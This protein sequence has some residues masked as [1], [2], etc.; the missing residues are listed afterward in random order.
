MNEQTTTEGDGAI[1]VLGLQRSGTT[2][3]AN[4]IVGSGVVAAVTAPEH[5]GVHESVFFSHFARAFGEFANPTARA[6]FEEALA[7]SDYFLLT[8][9]PRAFLRDT[10]ATAQD[11]AEVFERLMRRVMVDQGSRRWLEKSPHH[12]L[13]AA[14]LAARYPKAQFICVARRSETLLASRLAAYGRIPSR[15]MKRL[16]DL[17]RGALVNALYTRHLTGF[18]KGN[19]QV[20]MMRYDDFAKDI[21]PGRA[22]LIDFLRLPVAP[23]ALHSAFA[24]NSSHAIDGKTRMLSAVDRLMIRLGDGLGAVLP[25]AL[26]TAIEARRR[27]R[28]GTDWPDWVWQKSGWRP[29]LV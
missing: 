6:D 8:G 1:F 21:E 12:T 11:Y 4:M 10:V 15:G 25:L 23:T 27:K 29:P 20:L 7:Q 28:R 18:A 5:Q 26:L 3:L 14:E 13:L 19:P 2:W 9:L 16:G 17:L 24:A 22:A